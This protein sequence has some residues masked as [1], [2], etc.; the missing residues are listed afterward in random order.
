MTKLGKVRCQLLPDSSTEWHLIFI[1]YCFQLSLNCN[2]KYEY[3]AMNSGICENATVG[4]I[5]KR[6]LRAKSF[7]R[8][9][10]CSSAC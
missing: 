7:L 3:N 1:L 8:T 9:F 5:N 2:V 10:E 4:W 6:Q